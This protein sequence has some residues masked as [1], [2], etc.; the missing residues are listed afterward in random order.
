[1][2]LIL[3]SY[4]L[5]YAAELAKNAGAS[6]RAAVTATVEGRGK[7]GEA[8]VKATGTLSPALATCVEQAS[9]ASSFP[10]P[11]GGKATVK[12]TLD[13]SSRPGV[14]AQPR[15]R[16]PQI[17]PYGF[18]LT[19]LH[20]RYAKDG[21]GEDLVFREAPPIVGGREEYNVAEQSHEAKQGMGIN[22]FQA[23]YAIRHPWKGRITCAN[24]R[25]G[26]W[27]GPPPGEKGSTTPVPAQKIAYVKRENLQLS[28]LLRQGIPDLGVAG[29]PAHAGGSCAGA[30]ATREGSEPLAGGV[31]AALAALVLGVRRRRR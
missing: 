7:V 1:V 5:C 2:R 25:R 15:F 28:S 14:P 30:C 27:G 19:R 21:L 22:N 20:T 12:Y 31:L 18:T 3:P 17:N 9:R 16:G 23:R 26:V 13:F 4:Q 24:P 29:T 6:G 11:K 8:K 10:A